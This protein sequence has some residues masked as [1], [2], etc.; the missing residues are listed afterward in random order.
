MPSAGDC[1]INAQKSQLCD[2]FQVVFYLIS[3]IEN[4]DF[5]FFFM[6]GLISVDGNTGTGT[7]ALYI[8]F[9]KK[10]KN[11]TLVNIT[12]YCKTFRKIT[13]IQRR[14]IFNNV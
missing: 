9:L 7:S 12:I 3:H 11:K 13:I 8:F 14:C 4:I 6:T 10:Q 1:H 5:S 2:L